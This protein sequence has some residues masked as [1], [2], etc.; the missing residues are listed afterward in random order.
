MGAAREQSK[1]RVQMDTSQWLIIDAVIDNTIAIEV[2]DGDPGIVDLGDSIRHAGWEQVPDWP[3]DAEA[4][5]TWPP[6]GQQV[7][8]SLTGQQWSLVASQLERWAAVSDRLADGNENAE[9][10][11][12]A[13]VLAQL[14]AQ[15]WSNR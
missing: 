7:T 10:G 12:V 13:L 11:I 3:H 2:V 1:Y 9:R 4:L 14:S 8:M 15:G 6:A 5:K